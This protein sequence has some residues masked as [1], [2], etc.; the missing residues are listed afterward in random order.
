MRPRLSL[1]PRC[2]LGETTCQNH[3]RCAKVNTAGE[4][5]GNRQSAL[6]C[7]VPNNPP[8]LVLHNISPPSLPSRDGPAQTARRSDTGDQTHEGDHAKRFATG[9]TTLAFAAALAA[10]ALT[11]ANGPDKAPLE[12]KVRVSE[13]DS[14]MKGQALWRKANAADP[15]RYDGEDHLRLRRRADQ[16][17]RGR[18]HQIALRAEDGWKQ[19][20]SPLWMMNRESTVSFLAGEKGRMQYRAY[21]ILDRIG[22][23]HLTNLIIQVV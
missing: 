22:M 9:L 8:A 18:Y 6:N 23:E 5:F 3:R 21:C 11:Y 20:T 4:A 15:Q 19:E 10:P 17:R 13:K 14:S 7:I 16:P 2:S 12:I 1:H